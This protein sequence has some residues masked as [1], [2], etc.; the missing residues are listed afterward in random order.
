MKLGKK[1]G[2]GARNAWRWVEVLAQYEHL[3]PQ[4]PGEAVLAPVRTPAPPLI[5]HTRPLH[6]QAVELSFAY[7]KTVHHFTGFT[8]HFDSPLKHDRDYV[9][10]LEAAKTMVPAM[11]SPQ[12]WVKFSLDVF[13]AY[14]RGRYPKP[15]WVFS[16]TR[17]VER[18]DWFSWSESFN[19]VQAVV[20]VA[21][22]HHELLRRYE[23]VKRELLRATTLSVPLVE[24]IVDEVLPA[25]MYVKLVAVAQKHYT[26]RRRD[27]DEALKEGKWIW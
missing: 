1:I 8:Y 15:N 23:K 13:F 11:I 10:L 22:E 21:P 26:R 5:D 17:L 18:V 7:T 19:T 4:Y 24:E 27:L 12:A 3:L 20:W 14:A 25:S 16:R 9:L 2:G 6:K